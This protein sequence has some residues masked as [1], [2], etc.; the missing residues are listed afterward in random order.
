MA[1]YGDGHHVRASIASTGYSIVGRV[2]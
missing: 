2:S 1:A